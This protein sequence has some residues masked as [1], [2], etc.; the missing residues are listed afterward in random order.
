M[1]PNWII[2]LE[3]VNNI[4]GVTCP[5]TNHVKLTNNRSFLSA[6]KYSCSWA[7]CVYI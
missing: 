5:C 7:L 6:L 1:M 4:D 2:G 3:R